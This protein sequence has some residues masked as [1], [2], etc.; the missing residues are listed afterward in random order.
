MRALPLLLQGK[1]ERER[2]RGM[3]ARWKGGVMFLSN[4]VLSFI[5]VP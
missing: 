5:H 1:P 3:D 4:I 2:E